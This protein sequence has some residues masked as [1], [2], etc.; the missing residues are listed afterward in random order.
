MFSKDQI[1]A[2]LP[3][4]S[5]D[6]NEN[7]RKTR[8]KLRKAPPPPKISTHPNAPTWQD[9]THGH[10]DSILSSS[11]DKIKQKFH[12]ARKKKGKDKIGIS[13]IR[14][15][16]SRPLQPP[17]PMTTT[18][19]GRGTLLAT[20]NTPSEGN[21]DKSLLNATETHPTDNRMKVFDPTNDRFTIYKPNLTM[22]KILS[23]GCQNHESV[24][25][26]EVELRN[27]IQESVGGSLD[28]AVL[29]GNHSMHGSQSDKEHVSKHEHNDNSS[30]KPSLDNDS[31]HSSKSPPSHTTDRT[32]IMSE[33]DEENIK[34]Q[35]TSKNSSL[36]CEVDGPA[37]NTGAVDM[38]GS[39]DGRKTTVTGD[40]SLSTMIGSQ[41]DDDTASVQVEGED[42]DEEVTISSD[43][44]NQNDKEDEPHNDEGDEVITSEEMQ[45][46]E[47]DE[48]IETAEVGSVS[49]DS[50]EEEEG[51]LKRTDWEPL[52]EI[53]NENFI[54]I[55]A[56]LIEGLDEPDQDQYTFIGEFEGGY[57]HVRIFELSAGTCAGTYVVKTPSV[58][59]AARWTSEDAYMLRSEF[60]TM[61]LIHERTKC[62]IPEV[63]AACDHLDNDLGAPYIIMRACTG[64]K[65][66]N[67]WFEHEADK[68]EDT[69][70]PALMAKRK[71]FLQSLARAMAQLQ[72]L[73]FP[74]IGTLDFDE[75]S[76]DPDIGSTYRD[77]VMP[78][79]T[80]ADLGTS[81]A[82]E[83]IPAYKYAKDFFTAGLLEIY[84]VNP[85][86]SGRVK[87]TYY[88]LNEIFSLPPFSPSSKAETE[89]TFVLR[90][91]DLNLQNIF[92]DP[93]TGEVTGIIDWE[94]TVTAPRCIGFS[95]LPI[96][97]TK[98][99]FPEYDWFSEPHTP[100][101]LG[102]YRRIYA[103]AMLAATDDGVYTAKSDLYQAAHGALYGSSLGGS[104]NNFLEK[105]LLR[106][107]FLAGTDIGEFLDWVGEGESDGLG[108]EYLRSALPTILAPLNI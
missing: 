79:A 75:D 19:T 100:W 58:G 78:D 106:V 66:I 56:Q 68:N 51:P 26:L 53:P 76:T 9:K 67:L 74:R 46:D 64:I 93:E 40:G 16:T 87:A 8:N 62:P 11:L 54:K 69:P 6:T 43:S 91:E 50:E 80:I 83:E 5:R 18:A 13:N 28:R 71:T 101:C 45:E 104:C 35:P 14:G 92:C 99:A 89:E 85:T 61:K 72:N 81:S 7:P 98:D 105:V 94:R 21:E 84:Q 33:D 24:S 36:H 73:T 23:G 10:G 47:A 4:F 55:L 39:Q 108:K 41:A 65:A 82:I 107:P 49:E 95:S 102:E 12:W 30:G 57:N 44:K 32:S 20:T 77:N 88:L 48:T 31:C 96:F 15:D 1:K 103:E 37:D 52:R 38:D 42:E 86:S 3:S 34:R 70:P 25:R 27:D 2:L 59:T 90:H 60:G 97:L 63:L 22:A 29:H 17:S